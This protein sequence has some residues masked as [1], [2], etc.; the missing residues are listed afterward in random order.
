MKSV[1][2]KNEDYTD[3]DLDLETLET[4]TDFSACYGYKIYEFDE[5][6]KKT[7]R[8]K[9]KTVDNDKCSQQFTI[10]EVIKHPL[11]RKSFKHYDIGL[12]K[13]N[14]TVINIP[15]KLKTYDGKIYET[16]EEYFH[17]LY[18]NDQVYNDVALIEVETEIEFSDRIHPGCI[19]FQRD[20]EDVDEF[21]IINKGIRQ[22]L[23]NWI[24]TP[25]NENPTKDFVSSRAKRLNQTYCSTFLKTKGVEFEEGQFCYGNLDLHL[26]PGI[27]EAANGAPILRGLYHNHLGEIPFIFGLQTRSDNCG[28]GSPEIA[29]RLSHY[30]DWIDSII[31]LA[32]LKTCVLPSGATSTCKKYEECPQLKRDIEDGMIDGYSEF[33][34]AEDKKLV[35]CPESRK[36]NN[37]YDFEDCPNLYDKL[38]EG[39]L[40]VYHSNWPNFPH[41]AYFALIGYKNSDERYC[42]GSLITNRH[43]LSSSECV[44][45]NTDYDTVILGNESSKYFDIANVVT[46]EKFI[47]LITLVQNVSFSKEI[48]PV[49]LWL[50]PTKVPITD[51]FTILNSKKTDVHLKYHVSQCKEKLQNKSVI[52]DGQSCLEI[53]GDCSDTGNL[54]YFEK[55]NRKD[56]PH[57][58][59][60][61]FNIDMGCNEFGFSQNTSGTHVIPYT[62]IAS[63]VDWILSNIEE[64]P[65][66]KSNY[67]RPEFTAPKYLPPSTERKKN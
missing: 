56:I 62:Q 53:N 36:A 23:D 10:E 1:K 67:E 24:E 3:G 35:C 21:E 32:N 43:V 50:D 57:L 29:T 66:K 17:P 30:I 47:S 2:V 11:Y 49:C 45:E 26:I 22:N 28:F 60:I 33:V 61:L 31:S 13:L 9:G 65:I 12:I 37:V 41:N 19:Y 6:Y 42:E 7:Y 34:C 8:G 54:V 39:D 48:F 52:T 40:K 63:Q 51:Y 15:Q 14:G 58:V 64:Q 27:C 55:V 20:L 5:I 44:N 25:Y 4:P 38:I 16:K 59:G 46:N 18:K